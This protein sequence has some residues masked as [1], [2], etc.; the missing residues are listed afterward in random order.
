[1]AFFS[2]LDVVNACLGILSEL[3]VASLDD[4]HDL[5]AA[6]RNALRVVNMRE[7]AK[8]WWFNKEITTLVPDVES[9]HITLP[10]DTIRIDPTDESLNYVQ[11]GNKLYQ[12]TASAATDKYKFTRPVQCALIRL[13]PYD[14]LP[15][16]AQDYIA[17]SAVLHFSKSFD[18][19]ANRIAEL[20]DERREAYT[21]LNAEHIRNVNA[22]RLR[23]PSMQ[24]A[25][26]LQGPQRPY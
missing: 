1:M 10:G 13:L 3:P 14:E 16:A 24:R 11:R 17:T 7:Q 23:S 15:P 21:V 12:A 2:E 8:A 26:Y 5:V 18:A 20:K 9:G 25:L 19:D 6:A 4:E 22:N